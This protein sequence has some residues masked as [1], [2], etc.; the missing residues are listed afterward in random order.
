MRLRDIQ[1]GALFR[2][3]HRDAVRFAMRLVGSRDNGEDVVQEAY[4][5]IAARGGVL[6]HPR[7]YF[8][9]VTRNAAVDFTLR[10]KREWALRVDMDAVPE[11]ALADPYPS[12]LERRRTVARLAVLLNELPDACRMAF[13]LN[14]LE[15]YTH[16]EIAA[17][18]GISVS[19]VEKH[20]MRALIH[21]RDL[22]R[23]QEA[24]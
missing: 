7:S 15:G 12:L 9:T 4:L 13:V 24:E 10:E 19:M 17:R 14:K 21:C 22:M 1:L 16:A 2:R 8:F 18:M 23:R 3:H 11:T 20:M 5:R 6:E